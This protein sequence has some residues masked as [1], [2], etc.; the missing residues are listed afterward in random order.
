MGIALN[1]SL[2]DF[3]NSKV[4]NGDYANS[5]ELIIEALELFKE[6]DDKKQTL[7]AELQKGI[8]SIEAGRYT[9]QTMEEIFDEGITKYEETQNNP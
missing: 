2:E 5:S 7:R 6:Q 9:T 8:D 3:I 1:K 4:A